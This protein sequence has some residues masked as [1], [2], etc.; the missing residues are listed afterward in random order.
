MRV[1]RS[2]SENKNGLDWQ[3]SG[4]LI[5]QTHLKGRWGSEWLLKGPKQNLGGGES[6][7]SQNSNFT[8]VTAFIVRAGEFILSF[9]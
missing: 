3:G 8:E 7:R 5:M 2:E 6:K 1:I 9:V 4:R